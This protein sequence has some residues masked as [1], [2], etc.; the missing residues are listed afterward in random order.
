MYIHCIRLELYP[1][2]IYIGKF[3][4]F[5]FDLRVVALLNVNKLFVSCKRFSIYRTLI[6]A[7]YQTQ[8]HKRF[9]GKNKVKI[10]FVVIWKYWY[11]ISFDI[12]NRM[13]CCNNTKKIAFDLRIISNG[14][15]SLRFHMHFNVLIHYRSKIDFKW[16]ILDIFCAFSYQ[17]TLNFM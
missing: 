12:L 16:E 1:Y 13:L 7:E 10:N 5:S 11:K 14:I 2:F 17:T 8:I 3:Y 9:L 15:F 6:V 4:R